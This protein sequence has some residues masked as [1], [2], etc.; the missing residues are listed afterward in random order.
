[1]RS[2]ILIGQRFGRL[3]VIGMGERAKDGRPRWVCKCDCGK[4]KDKPVLTSSLHSGRTTSCGCKY[5]E[6]NKHANLRH[7]MK[8]ERIYTIWLGMRQRCKRDKNYANI[9]ICKEWD[10]FE[11]FRDW[12]LAN[13]YA[14]ALTIDR[15]NNEFGYCPE[16]CRWVSFK[17][18]ENNRRNN[19]RVTIHGETHTIAEW[20]SISGIEQATISYRMKHGWKNDDLLLKP[21][22]KG[23]K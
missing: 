19:V 5:F 1:M 10:L 15:I 20:S 18:Q 23:R 2:N 17:V 3:T 6:S 4:I 13:G 11:N 14:D 8:H 9:T 12:A 16:N 7:G 22:E 21:N